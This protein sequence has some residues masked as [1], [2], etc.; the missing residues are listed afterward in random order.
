M[1]GIYFV[2]TFIDAVCVSCG[3]HCV[4]CGVCFVCCVVCVV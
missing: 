4:V 2:N 1:C 3:V